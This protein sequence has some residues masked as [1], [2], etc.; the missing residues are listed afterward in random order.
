MKFCLS[1]KRRVHRQYRNGL[2]IGWVVFILEQK[3]LSDGNLWK[4]IFYVLWAKI[5]FICV[6]LR[7]FL[8]T[9]AQIALQNGQN[10][11]QT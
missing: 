3:I 10:R 5:R 9:T 2:Q 8:A 11:C 6:Y 7:L 4:G 1:V